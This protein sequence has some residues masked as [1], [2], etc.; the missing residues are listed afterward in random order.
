M[1]LKNNS[2]YSTVNA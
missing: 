2:F 1:T